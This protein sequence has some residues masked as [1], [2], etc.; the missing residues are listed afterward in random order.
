VVTIT[1]RRPEV[2]NA[3]HHDAH[4]EFDAAWKTYES[5]DQARVAI[6]TGQ[7]DRA[8]CAGADL[9]SDGAE[10]SQPYWMTLKPGG[11]GGLT[12]RFGLVKPVIAA[13]NGYALG[14]GFEMAMSCDIIVAA[15]HARFGLPE[16]RVGVVASDGGIHRIVRQLPLKIAM[17][18]LLTGR[19]L[20]AEEA[21][22][23]GVVNEVVPAGDLMQAARRWADAILECAPLSVWASKQSALAG[24]DLPLPDAINRRYEY[25][26]RMSAS[27]DSK[28]GRRAFREKRKPKWEGR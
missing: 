19:Q 1:I 13:V 9:R 21:H 24:L 8:F 7:G 2:M 16:A 5:D 15:E 4:L 18:L 28:E 26:L 12:E 6:L 20:T 27:E 14:G 22:R 17:G 3:L 25:A 11:F 23:W 10:S